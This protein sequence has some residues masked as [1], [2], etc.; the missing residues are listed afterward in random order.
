VP[1]PVPVP[2]PARR[3]VLRLPVLGAAVVLTACGTTPPPP[4]PD[5]TGEAYTVRL[6]T[7]S[8]ADVADAQTAFGLDLVHAVCADHP[9]GNVLLS[10]TS[11]AEALGL[12]YPAAGDGPTADAAARVLHLPEWTPDLVAALRDHTASLAGLHSDG[13][14]D[15]DDAPDALLM[16]NRLWTQQGLEPDDGYLDD[17]AT[18]FDTGVQPLDFAGDPGSAT[19]EI[20]ESIDA[21]TRGLIEELFDQPLDPGTVAVLTN[22]LYLKARWATP[23]TG[24]TDAPF[25]APSG[26]VTVGLMSGSGGQGR[27]AGGWRSVE[28][29]YRD[30]TLAAVAVLPPEGTDP[31]ALDATTLAALDGAPARQVGVELPRTEIAQT[32][33]LLPTLEDLGFP[34]GGDWSRLAPGA[35]VTDVVQKTVLKVDEEGTEAAAATGLEMGVS[36]RAPQE[37]VTFDRPFLFLLTDAATRSPLFVAVVNDPS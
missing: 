11:A 3:L 8:A 2:V 28:L 6:G 5:L 10:P 37:T 34:T 15:D 18:A 13:D 17:I 32:H 22:A 16:S 26:E 31:C 35:G 4:V 25:A 20:N 21:D 1:V 29:T 9:D 19:D 33:P 24:T 30:R 36:A 23:F 14:L 12:L 7:L 27:D